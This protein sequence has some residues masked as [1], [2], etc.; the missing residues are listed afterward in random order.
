MVIFFIDM[1]GLKPAART[2]CNL[3]YKAEDFGNVLILLFIF[4]KF[5][6]QDD[7]KVIKGTISTA[8]PAQPATQFVSCISSLWI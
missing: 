5:F 4:Y 8:Y 2:V 3:R 6:T 1:K 7:F